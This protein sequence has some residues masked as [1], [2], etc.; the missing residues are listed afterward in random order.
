MKNM[1]IY[2]AVLNILCTFADKL[3]PKTMNRQIL[4]NI[5]LT[6]TLCCTGA[7]HVNLDSLY[8]VLDAAIDSSDIYLRQKTERIASLK[9]SYHRSTT[10]IERYN[11]AE[12]LYEEYIPFENDSAITYQY[13]CIQLAERMERTDLKNKA[14]I[15]L[16]FQLAN[17]GFYYEAEMHFKDVQPSQLEGTIR[18]KYLTTMSQLYGEMAYYTHDPELKSK[19]YATQ[20]TIRDSLIATIDSTSLTWIYQKTLTLNNREKSKEAL[21][22]SDRWMKVCEPGSRDFA[23]MAFFRSEIYK[24]LDDVEMQRYWLLH[25]AII[26]VRSAIMD[27]GALWSLANSLIRNE[28]DLDRAYKYMDFSWNCISQFSPH[29]RSWQ[30]SPILT[31]INDEYKAKLKNANTRLQWTVGIISLLSLFTILLLGY[32]TKKRRQLAVAHDEL[33]QSNQQLSRLNA[34]LKETNE[35]LAMSNLRLHDSNRVKDEYI[36][37]FLKLC[38]EY[39]DKLDNYRIKINRKAKANQFDDIRKMTSSQQMKEDE[40]KELFDNFDAVF[41]HLFPNFLSEFNALLKPEEQ[42]VLPEENHLTTDLR[43]FALIRLGIDESSR[44]A[45]F[46][47]YSPNSIYNYRA[48]IKNKAIGDREDFERRVKEIGIEKH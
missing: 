5:F 15:D 39:I 29:M 11:A 17:S 7:N 37:K 18:D 9:D 6:F 24:N 42:I 20:H 3:K 36:T 40:V 26:D 35:Q 23:T 47:R 44:I 33:A 16:A 27:Q 45:D 2:L 10:D 30:V 13:K 38:S 25:A 14:L 12:Q 21:A 31:R 8:K 22:Y 43:I 1:T 28:G 32:V 48:R 34:Q 4:T 41:L 46:L 19:F